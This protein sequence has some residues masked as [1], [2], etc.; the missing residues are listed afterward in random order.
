LLLGKENQKVTRMFK[1]CGKVISAILGVM[2]KRALTFFIGFAFA[3][4][5]FVGI[6]AAMEPASKSE[7]CG[8]K[9]H[10]MKAAYRTWEL[11][12]H[13]ANKYGFRVECVDCHL[14]PK[15]EFFRHIATKAY[16]GGKD[17]CKHLFIGGYDFE[18]AL[19]RAHAHM[20]NKRCMHCH[21]DLLRR[22]GSS[23]AIKAHRASLAHPDEP[24]NKCVECHEGTG[25]ERQNKLFSP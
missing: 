12:V 6:N 20:P 14:P 5:C 8:S 3:I 18:K 13:G 1:F 11:S 19:K 9:C 22:P 25:H 16:E 4:L 23:A 10:E 21:D 24:E 17:I 7:F 2:K 15:D